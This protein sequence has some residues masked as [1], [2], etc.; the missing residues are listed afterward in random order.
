ME[1]AKIKLKVFLITIFSVTAVEVLIWRLGPRLSYGSLIKTGIARITEIFFIIII[2]LFFGNGM[3][4]IGLAHNTI[5][6]GIKRGIIW[7]ACFGTISI[8]VAGILFFCDIDIL[9][10]ASSG[11]PKKTYDIFLLILIGGI[12]G[13]I[14]EE[15]FFRGICYGF[16]RRFG[17]L[18][19]M[20]LTTLIFVLPHNFRT[21][22]PVIQAIGGA[23]FVI[24]YETEN[25]L[26]VPVVIHISGNLALFAVSLLA[27]I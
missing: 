3:K 19:A 15:F 14:F 23:V 4:S 25:N 12:I 27:S 17:I 5:K 8:I 20:A 26:M 18:I 16:L 21:G 13:P 2:I 11:L 9:H 22:I 7:S 10:L 6:R 24:A 1:T